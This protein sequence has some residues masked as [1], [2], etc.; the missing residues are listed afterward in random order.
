MKCIFPREVHK[1]RNFHAEWTLD[2]WNDHIIQPAQDAV[3]DY[4][5]VRTSNILPLRLNSINRTLF[6]VSVTRSH[7]TSENTCA[8]TTSPNLSFL[9]PLRFS[10]LLKNGLTTVLIYCWMTRSRFKLGYYVTLFE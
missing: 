5:K 9:W 8:S 7:E 10:R 1:L 2:G 3:I 4:Y 6:V